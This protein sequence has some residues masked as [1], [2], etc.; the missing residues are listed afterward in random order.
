MKK[1]QVV[2]LFLS[3]VL[4]VSVLAGCGGKEPENTPAADGGAETTEG[5]QETP[6]EPSGEEVT[7]R[8]SWWGGDA[9]HEATLAVIEA[10][11]KEHPN[12]HI[13][14]EYSSYD[15]YSEKKTTEFAS[16]TAPDIFQI[17]TGLGPEY[18]KNGVLYNLSET[19]I[20]WSNFDEN[21]LVQNGQFG[22]GSQYAIPT[23]Q[24]GSAIIVNKTLADEIGIDFTQQYDWDQF[25]EWGKMVQEY[26]P[27]CYL[28]SANTSYAMPFFVR[29]WCRQKNGKPI[30]NEDLTLNMTEEQFTE[31]FTLIKEL[32][33]NKVCA[34]A[35]YKAP[36]GDQD[37]EDPN[38]IAGKYVCAIGYTSSADVLSAAN[39]TVEYMA[40]NM[41]VMADAVND[42]WVND[43]PQYIGMYAKTQHPAEAALFLD[44]FYN[45]DEAAKLLGTVRSVPP[46]EKARNI[47]EEMDALNPLTKQSV[48]VSMQYNGFSDSGRTTSS[49]VTAIL[50]DAYDNVSYGQMEPAEAAAEVM[51]LLNDYMDVNR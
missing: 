46:T 32:Y 14:A 12:I 43:C 11:E 23:G 36:F 48:D 29:A 28:I 2:S 20:D 6:Q 33:D 30:M 3:A 47:C 51:E 27:E 39:D 1:R 41:P 45:S 4:A 40:G 13:E 21:F 37:Q 16:G 38:W 35:S 42:G 17:E 22:S 34:P 19:S 15:G 24:A 26:D 7:L 18:Y 5:T 50:I 31:C 9:R 44:Y 49:E 10:F 8:F 25:I